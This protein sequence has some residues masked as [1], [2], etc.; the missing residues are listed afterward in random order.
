MGTA[1]SF[2][3]ECDVPGAGQVGFPYEVSNIAQTWFLALSFDL[4]LTDIQ[5]C[6]EC[7]RI[8]LR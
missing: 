6:N 5:A 1:T 4:E 7:A 3:P 8:S 2:D